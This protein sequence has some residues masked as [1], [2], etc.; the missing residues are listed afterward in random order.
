MCP[1]R[2]WAKRG[3]FP[4]HLSITF[5]TCTHTHTHRHKYT[6]TQIYICIVKHTHTRIHLLS[7]VS[8]G[9]S[10]CGKIWKAGRAGEGRVVVTMTGTGVWPHQKEAFSAQKLQLPL[11]V[12]YGSVF[13]NQGEYGGKRMEHT[14]TFSRAGWF[15][16]FPGETTAQNTTS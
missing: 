12:V 16:W 15:V 10:G 6:H 13:L 4:Y 2:Y 3:W 9:W 1:K 14:F 7:V 5:H 11:P 8:G